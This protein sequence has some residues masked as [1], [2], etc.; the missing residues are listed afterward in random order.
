MDH[1]NTDGGTASLEEKISGVYL[2]KMKDDDDMAFDW[3]AALWSQEVDRAEHEAV[4]VQA[5]ARLPIA[6]LHGEPVEACSMISRVRFV[7]V[8]LGRPINRASHR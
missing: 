3:D 2:E 1:I 4:G 5:H 8:C 7:L 6:G